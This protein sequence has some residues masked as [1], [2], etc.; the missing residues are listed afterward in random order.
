MKFCIDCS[1]YGI[2]NKCDRLKKAAPSL[3]TGKVEYKGKSLSCEDER[4]SWGGGCGPNAQFFRS[5]RLLKP[6][7]G[8]SSVSKP[9]RSDPVRI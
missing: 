9:K 7:T 1:N 5:K 4:D 8:G 2:G 6:P 3:V